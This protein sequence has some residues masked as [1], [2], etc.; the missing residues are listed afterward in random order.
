MTTYQAIRQLYPRSRRQDAVGIVHNSCA[1]RVYQCIYCKDSESCC[2][3]YPPTKR[4]KEFVRT[5]NKVCGAKIV[6][7]AE[8]P[9]ETF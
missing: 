7:W 9:T 8:T 4:V 2:N 6:T 1:S 5:H 3:R